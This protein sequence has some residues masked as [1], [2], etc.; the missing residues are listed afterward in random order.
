MPAMQHKYSMSFTSGTLLPRE[1]LVVAEL[2]AE[3]A[4]WDAV[5]DRIVAENLLQMRT[6]NASRRITREVTSRLKTL[7]GDELSLLCEGSRDEQRL[8]LWLA[9]CKRYRFIYEFA[10]EVLREKFLRMDLI[11]IHEEYDIFF[12]KKAEWHPEVERVAPS[13]QAKQRQV[14]FKMLR[15]ADLLGNNGRIQPAILTPRLIETIQ[16]DDPA[17]FAIYPVSEHDIKAWRNADA[18]A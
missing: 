16:A 11:L 1:S 15:E 3:L 7:T 17:L 18:T 10:E 9:V 8:L 13:T 14:V 12:N 2:F 5:R 6:D 4:E